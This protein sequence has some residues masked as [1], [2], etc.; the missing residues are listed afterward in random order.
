MELSHK[1]QLTVAAGVNF[2][3]SSSLVK[4]MSLLLGNLSSIEVV[5]AGEEVGQ[6]IRSRVKAK[7]EDDEVGG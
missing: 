4:K 7:K 3:E 6:V 5:G 1:R 2:C